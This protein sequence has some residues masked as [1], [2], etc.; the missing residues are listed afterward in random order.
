M[1]EINDYDSLK[2]LLP[3]EKMSN[4]IVVVVVGW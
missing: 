1:A 2:G 4:I 3:E